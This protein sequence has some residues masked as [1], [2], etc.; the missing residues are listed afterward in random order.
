MAIGHQ[1]T[2]IAN[3]LERSFDFQRVVIK[4]QVKGFS[5]TTRS[6][7]WHFFPEWL[8]PR[9]R[10]ENRDTIEY[11]YDVF[12][13]RR[14]E[15]ISERCALGIIQKH[16]EGLSLT[17]KDVRQLFLGL[18]EVYVDDVN[19]LFMTLKGDRAPDGELESQ[20]AHEFAV[21]EGGEFDGDRP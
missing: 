5:C 20:A 13:K 18:S 14:I 9:F 4:Q 21:E 17:R 16:E 11:F 15:V 12:G 19:D 6:I 7:F 10:V 1:L 3:S 8:T 2:Q